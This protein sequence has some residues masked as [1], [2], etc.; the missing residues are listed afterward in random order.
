[1][2]FSWKLV[3]EI[4]YFAKDLF[5]EPLHEVNVLRTA[6]TMVFIVMYL[7]VVILF[8]KSGKLRV[9]DRSED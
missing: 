3:N 6:T 8:I 2:L 9:V 1:M 5:D 4:F 7:L